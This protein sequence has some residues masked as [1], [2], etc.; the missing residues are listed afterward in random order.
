MK[1]G[2][3]SIMLSFL[4]IVLLVVD[5]NSSVYLLVTCCEFFRALKYSIPSTGIG[6]IGPSRGP[7][8]NCICTVWWEV[9]IEHC[10]IP[11]SFEWL[12][13]LDEEQF[14]HLRFF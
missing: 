7:S 14:L 9:F 3:D 12:A 13:Q 2:K 8:H 5:S 4:V 1:M 11:V 10:S 6:L